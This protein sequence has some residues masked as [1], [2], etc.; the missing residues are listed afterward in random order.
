MFER[1]RRYVAR[2]SFQPDRFKQAAAMG[3][4]PGICLGIDVLALRHAAA[5]LLQD[6]L[7]SSTVADQRG[8]GL[9]NHVPAAK[10]AGEASNN[11]AITARPGAVHVALEQQFS[12]GCDRRE[13]AL[14][15]LLWRP[16]GLVS[17]A[18]WPV[19]RGSIL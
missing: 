19:A 4:D 2:D 1:G 18:R 6:N 11:V 12:A 8:F 13:G 9:A 16:R 10:I 17:R 15:A 7:Q 3:G 14:G 5:H